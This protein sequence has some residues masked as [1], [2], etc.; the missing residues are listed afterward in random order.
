MR[1][2]AHR[3]PGSLA[4]HPDH[5]RVAPLL[6]FSFTSSPFQ[7]GAGLSTY[8]HPYPGPRASLGSHTRTS[9]YLKS[10]ANPVAYGCARSDAN[11]YAGTFG[12]PCGNACTHA[13]TYSFARI[14]GG[15][16]GGLLFQ[17][18]PPRFRHHKQ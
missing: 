6:A 1:S 15:A 18:L 7:T 9:P 8:R 2:C 5:P 11:F 3:H 14:C 16:W 12:Y 17:R 13:D 10:H 4:G